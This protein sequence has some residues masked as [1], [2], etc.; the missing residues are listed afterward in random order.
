MNDKNNKCLNFEDMIE[1]LT[2]E[3]ITNENRNRL[4]NIN[5]HIMKC[6][7]CNESYRKLAKL[8][9]I[10]ESWS[11]CG[12]Y[13]AEQRLEHMKTCLALIRTQKAAP[14]SLAGRIENWLRNYVE[15]RVKIII[16]I[17]DEIK[18]IVDENC[19][20]VKD[21]TQIKFDFARLA[22]VR[23][24][25]PKTDVSLLI[26]KENPS[27]RIKINEQQ[28]IK[29][30]F[31][32]VSTFAPLIAVIPH[33]T[34]LSAIVVELKYDEQQKLWIAEIDNLKNGEYDLII[35]SPPEE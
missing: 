20:F 27:N 31:E 30:F 13:A 9:D 3:K 19:S 10:I 33:D 18:M 14:S 7:S 26:D 8:Y 11:I 21:S 15:S 24:E 12:Q 25:P 23:G 16:K 29:I 35:E 34:T 6:G 5:M 32:S 17:H 22:A 1:L 28:I 4:F 2:L